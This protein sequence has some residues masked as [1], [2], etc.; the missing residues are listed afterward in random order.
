MI[1]KPVIAIDIDDVLGDELEA[2][3]QFVNQ[4]RG[5]RLSRA[6]YL[7]AGEYWAYWESV[8]GVDK[9]EGKQI[10]DAYVA[11]GAKYKHSPLEGVIEAITKLKKSYKLIV[12]TARG[13]MHIEA[14]NKWLTEHFTDAFSNVEFMPVWGA[15][16][17]ITKAHIA[18]HHKASYLIDDNYEHC[19][20]AADAGIQ[21]LLFGDYGWNRDVELSSSIVRVADWNAVMDYF[22]GQR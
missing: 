6:D 19:R 22:D 9:E 16:D 20:L 21:T 1:N 3:R 17:V 10:Y 4:Y 14:T 11:S 2:V 12:I 5:L 13:D 7:V 15:K 8:W 18:G